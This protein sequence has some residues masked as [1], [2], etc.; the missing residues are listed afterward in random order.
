V[1]LTKL[2]EPPSKLGSGAYTSLCTVIEAAPLAVLFT[3]IAQSEQYEKTIQSFSAGTLNDIYWSLIVKSF[4]TILV[5]SVVWH[6]YVL[7]NNFVAWKLTAIDTLIPFSFA[8]LQCFLALTVKNEVEPS[9]FA[10]WI[11]A[12]NAFG[13]LAYWQVVPRFERQ[14]AKKLFRDHYGPQEGP[15]IYDAIQKYFKDSLRTLIITSTISFA[16]YLV[17]VGANLP[18]GLS[19]VVICIETLGI[20][21]WLFFDDAHSRLKKW[22]MDS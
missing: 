18:K 10:F 3:V 22:F 15:E 19:L 11:F 6:R 5:I 4:L 14:H 8:I 12:L 9:S 17:I 2:H 20:V 21:F 1:K 13:I 7:D 16:V